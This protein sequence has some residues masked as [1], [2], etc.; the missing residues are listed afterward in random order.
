MTLVGTPLDL[1]LIRTAR[2][3]SPDS[4]SSE[5]SR[6]RAE[7]PLVFSSLVRKV[8]A[9]RSAVE[10]ALAVAEEKVSAWHL[11]HGWTLR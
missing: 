4:A 8:S 9:T 7:S 6:S 5:R 3:A 2:K 10:A 1:P 11:P